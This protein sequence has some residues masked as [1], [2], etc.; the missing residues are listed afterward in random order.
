MCVGELATVL[1]TEP[2]GTLLVESASRRYTVSTL[3]LDHPVGTDRWVV[4]HAGFAVAVLSDEEARD[5]RAL[6]ASAEGEGA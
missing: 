5:V 2:D 6:R 1:A 3:L 4:T